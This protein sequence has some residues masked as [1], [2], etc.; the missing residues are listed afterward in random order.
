MSH[1]AGD[2]DNARP[3]PSTSPAWRSSL[4]VAAFVVVSFFGGS[5]VEITGE[6]LFEHPVKNESATLSDLA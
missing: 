3:V 6:F 5:A 1:L 4:V 2:S